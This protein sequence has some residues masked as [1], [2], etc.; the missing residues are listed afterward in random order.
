MEVIR[1]TVDT[2]NFPAY[3]RILTEEYWKIPDDEFNGVIEEII[4]DVKNG[5]IELIDIVKLYAY[6]SYFAKR[7]LI[8]YD[9][10]TI[11][12]IFCNG[13]NISSLKSK[14][15]KNVN[16]ELGKIAIA[17][18]E[19][20]MESILIHFNTLNEQLLEK[21]Y[22]EK[23]DEIMKCIPERMEQFYEKFDKECMQIPIF[24]YYDAFQ[25]LQR[26]TCANN[27]DIVLIKEKLIDRANKFSKEIEPEMQNIKKLKQLIEDYTN[28][29]EASIKIVLLKEFSKELNY[30]L[31]KY[32]K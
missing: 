16:E 4:Q 9:I 13:M 10:K 26:I 18:I 21:E 29:K 14:Y 17:E 2:G 31:D 22:R 5:K 6:F 7:N 8:N 15:C 3:K 11:K 12:T 27:E 28:G 23:A 30:I 20:D 32:N 25:L 19:K 24:K 1:N